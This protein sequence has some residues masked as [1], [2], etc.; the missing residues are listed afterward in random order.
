MVL[1]EVKGRNTQVCSPHLIVEHYSWD[2]FHWLVGGL[3]IAFHTTGKE[4]SDFFQLSPATYSGQLINA[5]SWASC[6]V[7]NKNAPATCWRT[8]QNAHLCTNFTFSTP[9]HDNG[10]TKRFSQTA[11][12]WS[13]SKSYAVMAVKWHL[14]LFLIGGDVMPERVSKKSAFERELG[15]SGQGW[16]AG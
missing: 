11:T 6:V 14:Q 5:L 1:R 8:Q 13:I 2:L 4:H 3:I 15:C 16:S 12:E 10:T 9:V 7:N